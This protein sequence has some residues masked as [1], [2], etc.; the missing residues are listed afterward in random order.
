MLFLTPDDFL[1]SAPPPV[2]FLGSD[3]LFS[4]DGLPDYLVDGFVCYF[5][6][7]SCRFFPAGVWA[8]DFASFSFL[9]LLVLAVFL[10]VTFLSPMERLPYNLALVS[11]DSL[12][13][14]CLV[15]FPLA[16]AT[17]DLEAPLV[18]DDF[19]FPPLA[20]F[21]LAADFLGFLTVFFLGFFMAF[22]TGS[23]MEAL[24]IAL[25]I[26]RPFSMR[27]FNLSLNFLSNLNL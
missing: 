5:L 14:F 13:F 24:A 16:A 11:F 2:D 18:A 6:P 9:A 17:P 21:P 22:L 15:D 27:F 26:G 4:G 25:I 8:L 1:V 7:A 19:D 3:F 10:P 12:V 23:V 20:Y